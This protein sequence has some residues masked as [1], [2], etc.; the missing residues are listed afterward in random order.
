VFATFFSLGP[1]CTAGFLAQEIFFQIARIPTP[2]DV[3]RNSK[4]AILSLA[5]LWPAEASSGQSSPDDTAELNQP[6]DG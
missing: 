4:K 5:C 6:D 3:P 1:R 2:I